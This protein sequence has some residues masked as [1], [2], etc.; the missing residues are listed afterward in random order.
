MKVSKHQ[1]DI[2]EKYYFD[3]SNPAAYAGSEK[4]FRVLGKK[5]PNTFTKSVIDAWLT[6]IDSYSV[7]KTPRRRIK[8]PRV[9]V[10]R[11]HEQLDRFNF[12]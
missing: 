3:I 9:V 8:T 10:T 5:Y 4:L 12:G 1:K 11:I 7:L 6:S 2:L